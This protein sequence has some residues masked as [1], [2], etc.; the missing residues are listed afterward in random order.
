ML[1][2]ERIEM[3]NTFNRQA[4]AIYKVFQKRKRYPPETTIKCCLKRTVFIFANRSVT[5]N[6]FTHLAII[7]ISEEN[8]THLAGDEACR[9]K[10]RSC[11]WAMLE[12]MIHI[13][14]ERGR[15]VHLSPFAGGV[16]TIPRLSR[17][18]LCAF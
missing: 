8:I 4:V 3:F 18:T 9:D 1:G 10:I 13:P 15:N 5:T 12:V 6:Y 7:F 17:N 14:G 11:I 16:H 2:V